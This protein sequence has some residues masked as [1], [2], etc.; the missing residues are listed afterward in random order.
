MRRFDKLQSRIMNVPGRFAAMMA[1][2]LLAA[3]PMTALGQ[4]QPQKKAP[5]RGTQSHA[6]PGSPATARKRSVEKPKSEPDMAWLEDAMKDPE[7]MNAAGHL[8]QRLV[9]ELQFPA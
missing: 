6:A 8:S 9:T 7:L 1:I 4:A 5:A 2:L 3:C